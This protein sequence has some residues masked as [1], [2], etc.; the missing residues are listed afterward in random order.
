MKNSGSFWMV[1]GAVGLGVLLGVAV[2]A[3]WPGGGPGAAALKDPS[4]AVRAWAV[5][6]LPH[7]GNMQLLVEALNDEDPDVRLLA[8]QRLGGRGSWTARTL[9]PMLKDSHGAVRCEAGWSL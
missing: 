3:L 1:G 2:L 5:R 4:P 8:V 9:V 6:K 7:D